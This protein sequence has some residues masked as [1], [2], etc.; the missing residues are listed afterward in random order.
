[1]LEIGVQYALKTHDMGTF[2]RYMAQLN[3]YYYDYRCV[4]N[5]NDFYPLT[6]TTS[7]ALPES[8]LMYQLIGANLLRLLSQKKIADFHQVGSLVELML[9]R[10]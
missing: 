4:Q 2:E 6:T 8:S 5:E 9:M 10:L 1:M 7:S 3:A